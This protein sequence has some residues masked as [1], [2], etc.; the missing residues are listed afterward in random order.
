MKITETVNLPDPSIQPLV[1]P[2]DIPEARKDFLKAWLWEA[3]ANPS[4][5]LCLAAIA[6]F[7]TGNWVAAVLVFAGTVGFGWMARRWSLREAWEFI[8]RK[9]QDRERALPL[10]W[11]LG[12]ISILSFFLGVAGLLL[13]MR[14]NRA[15]IPIDVA[16]VCFGAGVTAVLLG[17]V[18]VAIGL[19]RRA[20]PVRDLLLGMI[21]LVVVTVVAAFGFFLLLDFE[22]PADPTNFLI[23]VAIMGVAGLI[24]GI[25][26]LIERARGRRSTNRDYS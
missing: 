16:Q 19:I 10:R 20:R 2:L 3:L 7:A 11:V 4:V 14:L 23:G 17:Y 5:S 8:P 26:S 22:L 15:D 9:R 21:P 1:H 25:L 13:V 18:V 6:W 12:S 24:G